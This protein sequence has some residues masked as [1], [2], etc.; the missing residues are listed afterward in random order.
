MLVQCRG[1]D[2]IQPDRERQQV[3]Q[4]HPFPTS[5]TIL[6]KNG[7]GVGIVFRLSERAVPGRQYQTLIGR[8]GAGTSAVLMMSEH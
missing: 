7:F 1:L 4:Q 5:G 8:Y 2:C 6:H 3:Y